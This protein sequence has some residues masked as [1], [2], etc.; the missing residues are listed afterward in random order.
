MLDI[1][2]TIERAEVGARSHATAMRAALL[3]IAVRHMQ[4]TIGKHFK[5]EAPET[6]PG[7]A[8][9]FQARNQHYLKRKETARHKHAWASEADNPLVFTGALKQFVKNNAEITATQ[10]QSRIRLHAPHVLKPQQWKELSSVSDKEIEE[11]TVLGLEVY[12]KTLKELGA[13]KSRRKVS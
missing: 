13:R 3:A 11:Y 5:K 10:Y 4:V 12:Q 7:G 9:K 8:Y 6:A 1:S 2:I